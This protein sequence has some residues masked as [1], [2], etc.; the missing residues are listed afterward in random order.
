MGLGIA[1]IVDYGA[2]WKGEFRI[3][4]KIEEGVAERITESGE[5]DGRLDIHWWNEYGYVLK[6]HISLN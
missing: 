5:D 1:E 6:L 3:A 2:G 4:T